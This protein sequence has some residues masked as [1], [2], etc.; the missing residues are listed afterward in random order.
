MVK[1]SGFMNE[2]LNLSQKLGFSK[3]SKL[4]IIHADDAGLSHA[5]NKATIESLKRGSVNSYSI[6]V[7]CPWFYQIANFAKENPQYDYGIHLTLTCE[8]QSYKFGPVLS[9]KEVPSL[10]DK[11]GFFFKSRKELLENADPK[12]V[13]L[14]LCAQIDRA[15]LL[16]LMPSHL[17]SHM[18]SLG[19]SEDF[20][21][22]YQELGESYKLPIML[23]KALIK[24]TSG[25]PDL[26]IDIT[27]NALVDHVIL[28][29]YEAFK[30]GRLADFYEESLANLKNGFNLL[31]IHPAYNSSEMKSI[32]ENHPNFGS[33]WRQI[34]LDFFTSKICQEILAKNQVQLITWEEI[35]KCYYL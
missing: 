18:Y 17:D 29:N 4:L 30:N 8:W 5:E 34:D 35:K 23:N 24:E 11:N 20:L 12:E 13:K 2:P 7:P 25:N 31:L 28:G 33:E 9:V 32:T 19:I 6:M 16:G 14:E 26:F 27:K 21:T 22:I 15:L 3:N 1:L 10:V